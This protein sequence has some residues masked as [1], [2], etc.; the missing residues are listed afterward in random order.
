VSLENRRISGFEALV[1]WQHPTRGLLNPAEFLFVAE[2]TG[3]IIPIDRWVLR[4]VCFQM[5][6]WYDKYPIDPP[7]TVSVNLSGKEISK[8]D[9]V[10]YIQKVL[11]DSGLNPACL[12]LE[13]TENVIMETSLFTSEVFRKLQALGVQVQI[14][15]FGIGYSSLSY[16]SQ[17]P[18]NAL[19]IDQSFVNKMSLDNSQVK[20][21]QAIVMLAQRLDVVVV[22]EGV[23]TEE[24]LEQL[25]ELGC[26]FGQGYFVSKPMHTARIQSLLEEW[27]TAGVQPKQL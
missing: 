7:L 27:A 11:Y 26:G 2:E 13:I 5:K 16:L 23:E 25:R 18:V 21:I 15:D 3:L 6:N 22:A 10:D 8:P 20:I 17:F 19:K 14:D 1:R 9:L 4:Q 24:Q 12:K